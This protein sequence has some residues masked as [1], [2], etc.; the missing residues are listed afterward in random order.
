MQTAD[1]QK[2]LVNKLPRAIYATHKSSRVDEISTCFEGTRTKVL[3]E[4][5]QWIHGGD[6]KSVFWLNGMAGIG[7]TTIARTI[8]D[9]DDKIWV[10]TFFFS[11]DDTQA[12]DNLLVFPT[13]AHQLAFRDRTVLKTLAE[14]VRVNPDCATYPIN[15]QFNEFIVGPLTALG[16]S[17]RTILLIFDALDECASKKG[18]SDI[19]RLLLSLTS[20]IS[21]RL[22]ILVTSRPEEYIQSEFDCA[23]NHEKIVL[24]N[25]EKTIVNN[26]IERFLRHGIQQLFSQKRLPLPQESEMKLLADKADNLFIYAA[27]ALRFI[28]DDVVS[29][30][31]G[32]L[33]I[34]LDG[35]RAPHDNPYI[36]IDGLYLQV[37]TTSVSQTPESRRRVEEW[38]CNVIR[39]IVIVR[40]P[41]PVSALAVIAGLSLQQTQSALRLLR[42]VIR[43]PSTTNEA[44]RILHPSFVDFITH[45]E[46]CTNELFWVD[47]PAREAG[48]AMRCLELMVGSLR[49]NMAR[50]ED[51]TV[52]NVEVVDLEER[53]KEVLPSELRYAC[54]HWA[55]HMM[56]TERADEKCLA[57]L[58][59]FTHWKLLNWMEAMSLLVD[60]PSAILMMRDIHAWAVSEH[61]LDY[62]VTDDKLI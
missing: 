49:R 33:E 43:E 37:L 56:A 8:V 21:C 27:T 15:K 1:P 58:Q 44:P 10:A 45:K 59:K 26:D 40:E 55:S 22:R 46:R 12:S 60:V 13:L 51:E 48:L 9:Q 30:P 36:A 53:V 23:H 32:Q 28:G 20:N 24:H 42:S 14:M 47:V 38:I 2:D 3:E 34:I 61:W 50:M 52:R 4:I 57:L 31:Q 11:R 16:D 62:A 6:G 7:K 54:I 35:R 17:H 19:I 5:T 29:D 25:I 41:L 39:A 18:I